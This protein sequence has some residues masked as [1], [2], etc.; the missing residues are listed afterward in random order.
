MYLPRKVT[1]PSI[2]LC[3]PEIE[4]AQHQ[5]PCSYLCQQLIHRYL[6]KC[7]PIS[8]IPLDILTK[9]SNG[10]YRHSSWFMCIFAV[11]HKVCFASVGIPYSIKYL[12]N[13]IIHWGTHVQPKHFAL[14]FRIDKSY[15]QQ[16]PTQFPFP[17]VYKRHVCSFTQ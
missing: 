12:Y 4:I 5:I 11:L 15:L 13:L 7:T 17:F 6:H 3:T 8:N 9:Y 2:A 14:A 16:V 1:I 10:K